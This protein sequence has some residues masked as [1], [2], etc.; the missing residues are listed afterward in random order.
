MVAHAQHCQQ[1]RTPAPVAPPPAGLSA[2]RFAWAPAS[3]PTEQGVAAGVGGSGFAV[4]NGVGVGMR[5]CGMR[6]RALAPAGAR[7]PPAR[8]RAGKSPPFIP[9]GSRLALPQVHA[10]SQ[11]CP[12][13]FSCVFPSET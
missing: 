2:S 8:P 4:G 7:P 5:V 10:Q 9:C 13:S 11:T 12:W 1:T 3:L 6:G